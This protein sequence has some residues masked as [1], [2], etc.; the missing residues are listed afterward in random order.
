MTGYLASPGDADGIAARLAELLG[1]RTHAAALGRRGRQEVI[2][3]WSCQRMV[4]GYQELIAE[5]YEAKRQTRRGTDT[6]KRQECP[7]APV[8]DT[9]R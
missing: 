5:I 3:H 1:D 4:E 9:V 7:E 8:P 6:R 2:D